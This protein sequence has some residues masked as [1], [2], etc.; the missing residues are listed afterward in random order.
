[1]GASAALIYPATLALLTTTFTDRRERAAAIGIWSGVTGLAVALGPVSGG[2]LLEHFSWGSVFLVNVPVARVALVAG[3]R[4]LPESRGR[5]ARPVRPGR[6]RSARSS[7]SGCWSGR[8][9]RRRRTAGPPPRPSRGY[10]GGGRRAGRVRRLGAAPPRPAAGHAAVP[11]PAV[12][13]GER[14]DRAGVLRP[15]RLHLPDHPVLPGR[16]RLLDPAGRASRPC[17]SR[18]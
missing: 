15:V 1:M 16:P 13:G 11:Q 9:S 4:L 6:R 3:L 8:R 14:G 10:A 2:L 5:G 7:A 18:W 12:L 17:R